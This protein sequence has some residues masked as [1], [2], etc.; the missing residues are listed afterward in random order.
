MNILT[1]A[2][3]AIDNRGT[4]TLNTKFDGSDVTIEILD[5]GRGMPPEVAA[6]IF[7]PGFKAGRLRVGTGLGLSISANIIGKH[8]GRIVVDSKVGEGSKFTVRI[9]IRGSS[10]NE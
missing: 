9:P 2:I 7:E 10:K 1:N 6:R 4:I 3:E 5:T 8:S